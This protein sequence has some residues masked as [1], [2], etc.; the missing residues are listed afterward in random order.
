M[1]FRQPTRGLRWQFDHNDGR[2]MDKWLHYFPIY[3]RH[4]E[5]YRGRTINVLEIGVS[6]GGS[7]QMWRRYFGRRATIIGIDIEPR[8]TE[9]AEPGI[10]LH[11]G[12]QSDP[13]FLQQLVERYGT[14]DV[15]IDDGSHLPAHQIASVTHLWPHVADGGVYLVEDLHTN[16]WGGY[17]ESH[18]GHPGSFITWLQ[19]RIDDMHAFHSHEPDFVVNE[20]TTTLHGL[21]AYD[22][23]VV[24]DKQ[25]R[26]PPVSRKSG[27]PMFEDIYGFEADE[28]IDEHHRAQLQSLSSPSARLRR[29]ARDP[30]SAW[31]RITGRVR[32]A[33]GGASPGK[34]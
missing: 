4:F 28:L 27:R 32:R 13:V 2:M 26:E 25:R 31:R 6:H 3:E 7:L 24:L 22:S 29:A 30:R 23:I 8:V 19:G 12:D 10:E 33:P 15:V 5:P 17:Y 16:Y 1:R 20:W 34:R 9:L 14:F 11:V 18:R 21:H